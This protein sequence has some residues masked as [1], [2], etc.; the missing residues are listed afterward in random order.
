MG[1]WSK[2]IYRAVV[3]VNEWYKM[4]DCGLLNEKL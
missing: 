4:S 1:V 2:T 3:L